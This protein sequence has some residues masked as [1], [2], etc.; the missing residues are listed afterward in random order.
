M[1]GSMSYPGVVVEWRVPKI[2]R[3]NGLTAYRFA[4]VLTGKV[5]RNSAYDI[6]AGRS[7]RV[8]RETLYNV[9]MALRQLTGNQALGVGDLFDLAEESTAAPN[10]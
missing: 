1:T 7:K 3:E 8:D 6:A 2:L 9:V 10:T 5:N 4:E